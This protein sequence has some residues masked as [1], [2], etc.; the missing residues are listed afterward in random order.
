MLPHRR[1]YF[2]VWDGSRFL[3]VITRARIDAVPRSKWNLTRVADAMIPTEELIAVAPTARL[4]ELFDEVERTGADPVLVVE[5]G[6]IMGLV[7]RASVVALLDMIAG[8]EDIGGAQ[9]KP[10][11]VK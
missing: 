7:T 8:K 3:G 6:G 2:F 11:S 4:P 9:S 5:H 10:A 1:N